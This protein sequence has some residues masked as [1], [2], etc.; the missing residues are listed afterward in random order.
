MWC[1]WNLDYE[2][3]KCRKT[4]VD[5]LVAEYAENI[6]EVKIAWHENVCV[7]S[8][9]ICV[10]LAVIAL[11]ISIKFG[12]YFA[13]FNWYSKKMLLV[14]LFQLHPNNSFMNL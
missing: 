3:C 9:T 12:A 1:W 2:N 7:C 5:K 8:N 6:V 14:L 10:I 13:Y 11:A 4:I